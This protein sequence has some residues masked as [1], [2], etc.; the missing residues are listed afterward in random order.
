MHTSGSDRTGDLVQSPAEVRVEGANA[1]GPAIDT[2]SQC[3]H[4]TRLGAP[5]LG[6]C[7]EHRIAMVATMAACRVPAP[8]AAQP[9][10]VR[11]LEER[12]SQHR[13]RNG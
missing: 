6:R 11:V 8:T 5:N 10:H 4:F 1:I 12:V 7:A 2:C 9:G 13:R 3:T